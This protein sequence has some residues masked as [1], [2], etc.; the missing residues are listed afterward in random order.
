[1]RTIL[2]LIALFSLCAATAQQT[3]ATFGREL[4]RG[5]VMVY[6]TA[7][8]ASAAAAG[9]NKYTT[10]LTEWNRFGNVFAAQFT[11]PFA[12]ANRQTLLHINAASSA[13]KVVVNGHEAAYN[14]DSCL[15]ADFN[16]TPYVT[17]GRNTIEI[18]IDS[19]APDADLESWVHPAEPTLGASWIMSQPTLRVRDILVRTSRTDEGIFTAE[20]GIVVKTSSLN[21]RTSR[22]YYELIAPDTTLAATGYKD[23][24]LSMRGED[25]LRFLARVPA[26]KLWNAGTPVHYTLRVKTQHEGRF[27]EFTEFRLGFRTVEMHGAK[28]LVNGREVELRVKEAYPQITPVE[29]VHWRNVGFNA[30]RLHPGTVDPALYRTCDSIGMFIIAQ[31]PIDT[32]YSSDSRQKGG[33][34]SN[35]PARLGAYIERTEDSYHT[36]KRH[37]SVIAFSIAVKSSNGINLYESYLNM[38]RLGDS[39]PVIYID[40]AGEWNSDKLELR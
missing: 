2:S 15:P 32:H 23:M 22:V 10:R 24:T 25:T 30:L 20:M 6:P 14:A 37:P 5:E 21:A 13:Y 34:P 9:D 1:M 11:V 35:D 36:S 3:K 29:I 8:E 12:W 19:A 17:E 28:M 7:L 38:K 18:A 39:R 31:A 4:P 26:D 33:T 40:A 16:I 27:V